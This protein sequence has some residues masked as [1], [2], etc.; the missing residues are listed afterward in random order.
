MDIVDPNR[1]AN[2]FKEVNK[3]R[4]GEPD[5]W[6]QE[7]HDIAERAKYKNDC[8]GNIVTDKRFEMLTF[9]FIGL[10]S[11]FIGY[12]ADY[13]A[14][15]GKPDNLYDSD[16]PLGF[17][18]M[19]NLFSFYFTIEV[20]IRFIAY[21]KKKDCIFDGWFVFDSILVTFM[22]VETW[23][24]PIFGS[25]GP[26]SQLSV[27]RLLRLLRITR[28][29]RLMRSMPDLVLIV[30]GMVAALRTVS[31]TGILLLL[32]IYVW[33]ILFTSEF[34]QGANEDE[35]VPEDDP[36]VFFGTMGKSMFALFVMGTILDD[37]TACTNQIRVT[38]STGSKNLHYLALFI[39]FVLISSFTILNMLIGVICEVVSATKEG[40]QHKAI[41]ANVRE[42]IKTIF[43]KMDKDQNGVVTK[44]EF[45]SMR[46]EPKVMEALQELEIKKNHFETYAAI[47]FK[48]PEPGAPEPTLNADQ[49]LS[50]LLRLRPGT[51][52]SALDFATFQI[53][54]QSSN[55]SLN[56]AIQ[57]I[58]KQIA[59][60]TGAQPNTS[61][62][63]QMG[64][65][66]GPKDADKTYGQ[67]NASVS[68]EMQAEMLNQLE[69]TSE[70]DI[71]AEIQ[72]RCGMRDPGVGGAEA[73]GNQKGL[74]AVEAFEMLCAPHPEVPRGLSAEATSADAWSKETFAC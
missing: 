26:L 56:K 65:I 36:A 2:L 59:R 4:K 10:N 44:E 7:A 53:A 15:F 66:E 37:V 40:E 73:G 3:L 38:S 45:M 28:M 11:L 61:S 49:T 63:N 69:R 72:R 13:T 57:R 31:C 17:I 55:Q 9:F 8:F 64:A 25:G 24:L 51:S 16:T 52:V 70:A 19:E 41:E 67:T 21:R 68:A 12:D 48:P 30:K 54:V 42:S 50:M 18:F 29:A 58:E 23:I 46:K 22:V 35:D 62:T 14:R 34:H 71:R 20:V 43:Q 5:G 74:D 1:D 6:D 39:V 32:L 33:A 27:L 47:L 60:L